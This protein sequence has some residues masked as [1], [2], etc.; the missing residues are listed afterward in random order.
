[1]RR[2][3]TSY[4]AAY[5]ATIVSLFIVGAC[6]P[7]SL[8]TPAVEPVV[9]PTSALGDSLDVLSNNQV[10]GKTSRN[11][12]IQA[13][14]QI[15]GTP[16][17]TTTATQEDGQTSGTP[18]PTATATQADGQITD[19]LDPTTTATQA[20]IETIIDSL[21]AELINDAMMDMRD[22]EKEVEADIA[23]LTDDEQAMIGIGE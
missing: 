22:L 4:V 21:L 10:V 3:S 16:D 14:G 12:S 2:L 6:A 9:S 1:M 8:P 11:N 7:Q 20:D 15:T 18:D 23:L 5:A 17:P 13:D 19:S